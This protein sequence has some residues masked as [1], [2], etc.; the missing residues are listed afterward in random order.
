MEESI[1]LFIRTYVLNEE[2]MNIDDYNT[3]NDILKE[4]RMELNELEIQLQYNKRCVKEADVYINSFIDSEPD[5]FKIFSPRNAESLYKSEINKTNAEKAGYQK[6]CHELEEKRVVLLNRIRNI[7]NILKHENYHLTVL[8]L[9]EEDRQRIARDLHDTSLQNLAHLVHKI[10]LSSLYIDKDPM[11]AKL[12]LSL[13]NKCL[14]ETIDEIRNII[15][16][17]RPMSFDDLGLKAAFERLLVNINENQKYAVDMDI[18]DVS[19]ETNLI[20][21]SIYRIVQE[22]LNNIVKHSDAEKILFSCK[23]VDGI[24]VLDINDDGK[25]FDMKK[26][27]DE[28]HFGLLLVQE[29]VELLNGKMQIKSKLKKGTEIHIEIPL[30]LNHDKTTFSEL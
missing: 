6:I 5:D 11:Q 3:L 13:V 9:Q 1:I 8:N 28:K 15:F 12:E 4:F 26:C 7:E 19:C 14:K 20:L 2:F 16:D 27:S 23:S 17:L 30:N 21:V 22:C 29:R 10:E 25:G 24:C 18:E